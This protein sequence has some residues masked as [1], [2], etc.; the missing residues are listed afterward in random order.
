MA[1]EASKSRRRQF[2]PTAGTVASGLV[3]IA[4]VAAAVITLRIVLVELFRI[5]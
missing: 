2:K 5:L 1:S 4:V 3:V